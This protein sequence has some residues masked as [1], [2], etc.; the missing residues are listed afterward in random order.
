M[1]DKRPTGLQAFSGDAGTPLAR[2][3]ALEGFS[4][5]LLVGVIPLLALQ[6]LGSKEAVTRAYLLAS[7]LTLVITLNFTTLERLLHRRWVVTL[8]SGF[9][10]V[11]AMIFMLGDGLEIAVAIGL[12]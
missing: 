2:L 10:I 3:N 12:Q 5:A 4:R 9:I 1:F 8:G 7:L 6:A 11:A